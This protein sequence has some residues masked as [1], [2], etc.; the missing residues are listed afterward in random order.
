RQTVRE[1][2]RQSRSAAA[3]TL[4][5]RRRVNQGLTAAEETVRTVERKKQPPTRQV[6]VETS[7]VR[8]GDRVRILA[9][10]EEGEVLSVDGDEAEIQMGSLKVRQPLSGLERLGKAKAP[11]GRTSAGL[12]RDMA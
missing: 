6:P 11:K 8:K 10:G 3:S 5:E 4:P 2:E 9:F 7:Q 1:I 12:A